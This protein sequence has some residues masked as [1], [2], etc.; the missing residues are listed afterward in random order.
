MVIRTEGHRLLA[1]T[2]KTQA[3]IVQAVQRSA[4]TVHRW[5]HGGRP[6]MDS[7]G[8]LQTVFGIPMKTWSQKPRGAGKKRKAA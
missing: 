1:D 2:G 3:E 5:F 4:P 8:V 7:A 6:D